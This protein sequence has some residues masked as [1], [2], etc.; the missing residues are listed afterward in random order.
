M[1]TPAM[2]RSHLLLLWGFFYL[3]HC[4]CV[5][6]ALQSSHLSS[7]SPSSSSTST[8]TASTATATPSDNK[9]VQRPPWTFRASRIYYQ[10]QAIPKE[11]AQQYCPPCRSSSSSSSSSSSNPSAPLTLVSLGGYT[12]GGIFCVEYDESPI[13]PYREVALLSSLVVRPAWPFPAIGAWASH[14]FV[15]SEPAARYGRAFWGLP[16]TVVPVDFEWDAATSG[17]STT[18]TT[19]RTTTPPPPTTT[20]TTTTADGQRREGQGDATRRELFFS[21]EAIHMTGWPKT[22]KKGKE[23]RLAN[24]AKSMLLDRLNLSLPSFSGLIPNN[25]QSGVPSD[26]ETVSHL[27][28]YPLSILQPSSMDILEPSL[29]SSMRFHSDVSSNT[30]QH[31]MNQVQDLLTGS[32]PLI[33]V[34]VS[35][36]TLVAGVPTVVE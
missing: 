26:A 11:T 15:N 33:S 36:V 24:K 27:L 1:R 34:D 13:G 30:N 32:H 29:L 3:C 7:S 4:S 6:S 18:A 17:A 12:L 31:I 35:N 8:T 20:T 2:D 21:G 5:V 19:T 14:I 16:A 10:F 23:N 25:K 28:Q 22:T 9:A